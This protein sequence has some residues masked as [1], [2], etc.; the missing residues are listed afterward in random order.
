[1]PDPGKVYLIGAGPGDPGLVTVRARHLLETAD[2]I[3]YDYLANA[4]LL[5]WTRPEAEKIY[6]GKQ[7]GRHSIPQDEIEEILVDRARKGKHVVRLK[8][9]DPFVF[10]R[11]GEEIAELD[12]DKIPYEIVPGVT[13]PATKTRRSTPSASIFVNTAATPA[14][15]AS[16]WA[17]ASSRASPAN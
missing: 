9:G 12:A 15:S 10:G 6:V 16:T 2:V 14:P 3:V 5:D 13:A 17:S 7:A 4:K 8:G 1:M 11:G